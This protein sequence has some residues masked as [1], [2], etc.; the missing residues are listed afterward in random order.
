THY[1]NFE[2]A[3][4]L[5]YIYWLLLNKPKQPNQFPFLF[6]ILCVFKNCIYNFFKF[7]SDSVPEQPSPRQ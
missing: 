1:K 3:L 7:I 4:L 5:F 6:S 2:T